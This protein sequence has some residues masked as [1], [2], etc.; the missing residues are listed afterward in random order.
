MCCR[1]ERCKGSVI[2]L[3]NVG[4]L[5]LVIIFLI[6]FLVVG[7]QD[8]P[9]VAVWLGRQ[10]RALRNLLVQLKKESG[11]SDFEKEIRETEREMDRE[12]RKLKEE[13]DVSRDLNNEGG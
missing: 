13:A 3:F 6:A 7:P 8:L 9:K 10:V 4:L 5:E 2:P 12:T 11:W 1:R